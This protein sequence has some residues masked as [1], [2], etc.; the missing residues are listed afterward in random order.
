M[1]KESDGGLRSRK[2]CW[3]CRERRKKCDEQRPQCRRCHISGRT[4]AGYDIR[5]A[6]LPDASASITTRQAGPTES[7]ANAVTTRGR[8]SKTE[9]SRRLRG[10]TA[11]EVNH[12]PPYAELDEA[13]C[14]VGNAIGAIASPRVLQPAANNLDEELFASCAHAENLYVRCTLLTPP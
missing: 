4:C 12:D 14:S 3:T 7:P 13:D 10:S 6:W 2:G 5:L 8:R 9:R 11:Q 1:P